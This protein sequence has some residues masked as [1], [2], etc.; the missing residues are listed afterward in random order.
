M[1]EGLDGVHWERLQHAANAAL[2]P[3]EFARLD[4]FVSAAAGRDPQG[5]G[6]LR[7][8]AQTFGAWD[9]ETVAEAAR[10]GL[11]ELA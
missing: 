9:P 7:L 1:L 8:A 4:A 11:L 6:H 5:I 10:S 3:T 2:D